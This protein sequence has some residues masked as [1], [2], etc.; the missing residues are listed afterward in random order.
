[1][2]RVVQSWIKITQGCAKY[3]LRQGFCRRKLVF[4]SF[5]LSRIQSRTDNYNTPIILVTFESESHHLTGQF[6]GIIAFLGRYD[7]MS[8]RHNIL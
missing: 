6:I 5:K 4:L 8:I 7:V 1:M 3:P 2:G